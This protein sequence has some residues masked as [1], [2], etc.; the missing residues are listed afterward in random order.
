MEVVCDH[1][2]FVTLFHLHIDLS[3]WIGCAKGRG[4][5]S[6]LW[7]FGICKLGEGILRNSQLLTVSRDKLMQ[8][9]STYNWSIIAS[10]D[11]H[12]LLI[13]RA[14]TNHCA[15][16]FR[17]EVALCCR[18]AQ[19]LQRTEQNEQ[20]HHRLQLQLLVHRFLSVFEF[21]F[22]MQVV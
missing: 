21:V 13:R 4:C 3:I 9:Q 11:D 5:G 1:K 16:C 6:K 15:V 12:D 20:Q 22:V 19:A 10:H 14:Q 2:W 8:T 18:A 7:G 17:P